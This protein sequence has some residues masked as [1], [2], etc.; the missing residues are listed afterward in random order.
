MV[1]SV[2][3]EPVPATEDE[4]PDA[5][6]PQR[7]IRRSLRM[8]TLPVG[9]AGRTALGLGKKIGGRPAEAV[10]AQIQARTAEQVFRVLG[11]LKGGAMKVGQ[12]MSVFEAA[13]P[14]ETA[15]PYRAMLTKLQEAA[16]PM[17]ADL[18]TAAMADELGSDWR[19]RFAEFDEV[20]AAAASIGQVHKAIARD[21]R[22]VAVKIQYPGAARA[23]QSDLNQAARLGRVFGSFIPGLEIKPLL[24][25]LKNRVAEELDYLHESR[26]Q[27]AFAVAFEDDPEFVVPHVL[28]AGPRVIVSEW[29]DGT[30]LS[31]IVAGGS[32]AE[33]DRAGLLYLRF[34]LSG[35]ARAGL[36]HADPHPGNFR[37]TSD[38]RL[39]VVDYGAVGEM[40]AGF[41]AAIGRLLRIA[42]ES[43]D[44]DDVL[45]GLRAEGFVK[46]HI[47][48]DAGELIGYLRPF[49]EPLGHEQFH[50]TRTWL[51]ELF[52]RI[53]D[54]RRRDFTVGIKLNLP[55]SY[56]LI[57]RVWM[58]STAVL[59]QLDAHIAARAE[60]ARWVPQFE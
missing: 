18:V 60:V 26:M 25:E 4:H 32:V 23:L 45:A 20:P 36:L 37:L 39:A 38:G 53:N 57:H 43:G 41:P 5:A 47:E 12:A 27:R 16:P 13:L 6:M 10:N 24:A 42:V 48:V 15:E 2:D 8:A 7:A 55:P 59:C 19:T 22:V 9:L 30:P 29:V 21:G 54:P 28:A 46:P 35:P 17:P 1:V 31:E 44:A 40:P 56:L 50:Y 51:R 49:I 58:G 14:E 34:L 52:Q 33:R 3:N 11:E